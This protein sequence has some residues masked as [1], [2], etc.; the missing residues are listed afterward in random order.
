MTKQ[1]EVKLDIWNEEFSSGRWNCLD[2]NPAERGRHAIIGMYCQKYFPN[3]NVLDVGCGEGTLT[4][5]LNEKQKKSYLGVD[6]SKE[7]IKIGR[8]KRRGINF[9]CEAAEI[10]QTKRKFDVIVFNEVLY[11]VDDTEIFAKYTNFLKDKGLVILSLYRMKSER[12]DRPIIK[13]S[14]K[15]FDFQEALEVSG[16]AGGQKVIWRVEVLKE[17]V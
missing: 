10:F 8:K 3:G 11:Y 14:R 16:D 4:D 15:F 12:H 6:I 9:E 13:H 1:L 5:F 17:N 7:A 2:E